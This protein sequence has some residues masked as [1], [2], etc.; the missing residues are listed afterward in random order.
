MW[1]AAVRFERAVAD[2]FG[3]DG[4]WLAGDAAHL[5]FPFGVHS[6]NAGI[7]EAEDLATRCER[8]LDGVDPAASLQIYGRDQRAAWQSRLAGW[9]SGA[10]SGVAADPWVAAHAPAI[11]EA[12]PLAP[13]DAGKLLAGTAAVAAVR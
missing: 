8:I 7:E 3:R 4:V 5:A 9:E 6:M 11:V 2:T 12:L 13:A 1:S 10:A